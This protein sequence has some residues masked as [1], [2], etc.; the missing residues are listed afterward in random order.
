MSVERIDQVLV[1]WEERL[2]RVDENLLALEGEPTYQMLSGGA[3]TGGRAPL[4]GVTKARVY[5]A[6]DALSELFEHRE[7][8]TEV[9]D[10]A[11]A[12]RD[13]I[14]AL[15]FWNTDE[16]LREVEALLNGPSIKMGTRPTPLAQRNLLDPAA[17]D[18][19]VVPEQLLQA[20]VQA[21][22]VARRA[23]MDV[24]QAWANVEPA[25]EAAEREMGDIRARANDLGIA[26]AVEPELAAAARDLAATRAKV[27]VDPLGVSSNIAS[28]LSPR[29]AAVRDRVAALGGLRDKVKTSL[30]RAEE[31]LRALTAAHAAAKRAAE[32]GSRE[33][34]EAR[35]LPAPAGDALVG[36][37]EP[38]LEKLGATVR[39]GKLQPAEVGLARWLEAADGYLAADRAVTGALEALLSRRVELTGRLSARRAQAQAIAARRGRV[40][41]PP[42]V[43][44]KAVEAQ[45]LL[46]RRP[47]SLAAATPLVDAYEAAV[48]AASR[49]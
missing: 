31:L 46:D 44:A 39:A 15:T 5:P 42:D 20:M 24:Q 43:E 26:A 11:K 45:R 23:V 29:L 9:L 32:T 13:S 25:L 16:K 35:T 3:G 37:L 6:L 12:V 21:Y 28:G 17:Q 34:E 19:A 14:S 2:K 30:A 8:L 1:A 36:G 10:R 4:E 47:T 48:I 27:A 41:L 18:V 40:S 22:D 38:W 7:R 49:S 33:I